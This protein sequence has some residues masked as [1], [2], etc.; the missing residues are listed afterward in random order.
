MHLDDGTGA[1]LI[2][3]EDDGPPLTPSPHI[4]AVEVSRL[5][6]N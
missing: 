5:P 6:F 4:Y 1:E 3:I 2:R